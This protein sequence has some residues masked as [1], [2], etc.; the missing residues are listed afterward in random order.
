MDIWS[1]SEYPG[2][3]L[4]NLC[5]NGFRFDGVKCRSMEGF[6][7]SLKQKNEGR[8]RQVCALKGKE[9]KALST[10]DWQRDQTVW[11][12][13]KAIGR[14][15]ADFKELVGKAYKAL[16][17]QNER[18]RHAL[19]FTIGKRLLHSRG[20]RNSSETILTEQEF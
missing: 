9:A 2:D 13:G 3:V 20:K 18:F 15:S 19:L 16:F 10:T 17:E 8:Q 7:Q 11:W 6:L 1:K 14:Q 12:K 5:D 4:S